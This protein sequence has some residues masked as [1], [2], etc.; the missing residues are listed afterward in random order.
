MGD[1][2]N[3]LIMEDSQTRTSA[4]VEDPTGLTVNIKVKSG[5]NLGGFARFDERFLKPLFIRKFTAEV[6]FFQLQTSTWMLAD[7]AAFLTGV[8]AILIF[9]KTL[10]NYAMVAY[11]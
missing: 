3:E 11:K 10:R 9:W 6:I 7:L 8:L 1:A 5:G 2:L 4:D